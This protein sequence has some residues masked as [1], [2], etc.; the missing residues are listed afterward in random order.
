MAPLRRRLGRGSQDPRCG[1]HWA[2]SLIHPSRP[3]DRWVA[4]FCWRFAA[5]RECL[6]ANKYKWGW[7]KGLYKLGGYFQLWWDLMVA[8]SIYGLRFNSRGNI[9]FQPRLQQMDCRLQTYTQWTEFLSKL[10]R[11]F[12]SLTT[13]HPVTTMHCEAIWGSIKSY[14][15]SSYVKMR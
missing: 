11:S 9:T 7:Q 4:A 3:S 5:S 13:L 15:N 8:A 2:A 6:V 14:R 10:G 1:G 12:I